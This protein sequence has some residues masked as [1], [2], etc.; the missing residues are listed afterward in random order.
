[1][2]QDNPPISR[3]PIFWSLFIKSLGYYRATFKNLMILTVVSYLPFFVIGRFTRSDLSD[4][5]EL[6]HGF[7]LDVLVCL[8]LPT[9]LSQSKVYPL[10]TLKIFQD[11]FA[12]IV[13][14]ILGQMFFIFFLMLLFSSFGVMFLFFSLLPFVFVLFAGQ[15]ALVNGKPKIME[16]S[17]NLVASFSLVKEN[18]RL[19]LFSYLNISSLM[20]VPI[21][22]FSLYYVGS[23]PLANQMAAA[24]ESKEMAQVPM[25]EFMG[26][27]KTIVGEEGYQNGRLVV[28]LLVRPIKSLFMALLFAQLLMIIAPEKFSR[29]FQISGADDED[30]DEEDPTLKQELNHEE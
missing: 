22:V 4:P 23:H 5:M 6:L 13:V 21:L 2:I 28:H 17:E 26:Q 30:G 20:I 25:V 15:F 3:T 12:Q 14:I 16:L 1:M 11:Y 8:A 10:E 18:F 7:L 19:V 29:F 24:S 9:I 27:I